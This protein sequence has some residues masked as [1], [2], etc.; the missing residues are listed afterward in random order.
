MLELHSK[1]MIVVLSCALGAT[2]I[3]S[4][5]I[6]ICIRRREVALD[7]LDEREPSIERPQGF[8][9]SSPPRVQHITNNNYYNSY[10]NSR[11]C[12]NNIRR[13]VRRS[14]RDESDGIINWE[15]R[16]SRD[17][18]IAEDEPSDEVIG[19]N[20]PVIIDPNMSHTQLRITPSTYI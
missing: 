13:E 20:Q 4:I 8:L 10:Y 9:D 18:L 12:G 16:G 19:I 11:E 14:P 7:M 6:C 1:M 15:Y 5:A 2:I 17:F 3:G